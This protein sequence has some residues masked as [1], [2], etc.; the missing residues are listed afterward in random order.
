MMGV[1]LD[2]AE[3]IHMMMMELMAFCSGPMST[4]DFSMFADAQGRRAT[5]ACNSEQQQ[6]SARLSRTNLRLASVISGCCS[7]HCL[8][9]LRCDSSSES[10][11]F[12]LRDAIARAVSEPAACCKDVLGDALK[13][14]VGGGWMGQEVAVVLHLTSS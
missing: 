11:G 10:G 7:A 13:K 3:L 14:P 12:L 4:K 6:I 2:E 5:R 1:F 9:C 8:A